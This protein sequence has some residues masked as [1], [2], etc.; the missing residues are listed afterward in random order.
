MQRYFGRPQTPETKQ[1][2]EEHEQLSRAVISRRMARASRASLIV[3]LTLTL[4]TGADAMAQT[5]E[6]LP[7]LQ[8]IQELERPATTTSV[9]WSSS[10][11]MLAAYTVTRGGSILSGGTFTGRLLTIWKADGQVLREIEP[12]ELFFY[13]D[14]PLAFVAGDKQIVTTAWLKS[15][16]LAFLV[17]DVA[18]G[19]VVREIDGPDPAWGRAQTFVA[20]PDGSM[21]AVVFGVGRR[22]AV[23]LYSTKDWTEVATL[24]ETAPGIPRLLAFS[25][26]GKRLAILESVGG[27]I[28]IYD[29]GAK[30]VTGT[31]EPFSDYLRNP[32]TTMTFSPDGSSIA[33]G[34]GR[35]AAVAM[36]Q[37]VRVFGIK[38]GSPTAS[39]PTALPPVR[40][41][42]WSPDGKFLAFITAY[43]HS[44][45][46]LWSPQQ[47][48]A[49][50]Q[51]VELTGYAASLGFSPD[52]TRLAVGHGNKVAIYGITR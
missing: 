32:I 2:A 16:N 1:H 48:Q 7:K 25:P 14:D 35:A 41:L 36:D 44:K 24:Q 12:P 8:Q 45:L 6:A 28:L 33:I 43:T 49:S 38:D 40:R 29:L 22:Q 52:G 31:L 37:P 3:S 34:S 5:S 19:G 13:S 10:G 27:K 50:E 47:P 9:T 11:E 23:G 4:A 17:F 20:S 30:R 21:L 26:D 18:T 51:T 15:N 39:F 42:S 46:H